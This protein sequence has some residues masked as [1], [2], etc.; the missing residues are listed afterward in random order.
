MPLQQRH[1]ESFQNLQKIP[2]MSLTTMQHRVICSSYFMSQHMQTNM[3]CC[4]S[5]LTVARPCIVRGLSDCWAAIEP[6]LCAAI[7]R[8][9]DDQ[10]MLRMVYVFHAQ[11]A[12]N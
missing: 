8:V 5:C 4:R 6:P 1:K 11:K 2:A 3:E 7:E 12:L 10:I 9:L